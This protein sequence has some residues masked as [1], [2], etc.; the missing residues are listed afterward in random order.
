MAD[1]LKTSGPITV[2]RTTTITDV[3]GQKH[4]G[5]KQK[6]VVDANQKSLVSF[7]VGSTTKLQVAQAADGKTY[8]SFDASLFTT[9]D[10]KIPPAFK[11]GNTCMLE[12]TKTGENSPVS[13]DFSKDE[14][15]M[16]IKSSDGQEYTLFVHAGGAKLE[17]G[18]GD[19]RQVFTYNSVDEKG[20]VV[21]LDASV[22]TECIERLC[23]QN[24]QL[25]S[26]PGPAT[27]S[28]VAKVKSQLPPYYIAL[29]YCKAKGI[30]YDEKRAM[31]TLIAD[32]DPKNQGVSYFV[33]TPPTA[34]NKQN[35]VNPL[36][37][38]KTPD[39]RICFYHDGNWLIADQYFFQTA[40]NGSL[41]L[42]F[43]ITPNNK[44]SYEYTLNT[45]AF[46]KFT[47]ST[48]EN[49]RA[50][51]DAIK[52]LVGFIESG[53]T[54]DENQHIRNINKESNTTYTFDN[55]LV[56]KPAGHDDSQNTPVKLNQKLN[57][58]SATQEEIGGIEPP[59]PPPGPTKTPLKKVTEQKK[60]GPL[61]GHITTIL[62]I[63]L[64]MCS[65]LLGP[66]A[67]AVLASI[68]AL[69]FIG[70]QSYLMLLDH[71]ND[72]LHSIKT[73]YIDPL[74]EQEREYENQQEAFWENDKA[75]DQNLEQ[76]QGLVAEFGAMW[77]ENKPLLYGQE[78]GYNQEN[79]KDFIV[80]PTWDG[81]ISEENIQ[82]RSDLINEYQRLMDKAT[83]SPLEKEDVESFIKTHIYKG[84]DKKIL[85]AIK[86][87]FF[88]D[89]NKPIL[90]KDVIQ[91]FS[92]Y[93]KLQR[94]NLEE[95]K[96]LENRQH[97]IL[98]YGDKRML[99]TAIANPKLTPEQRIKLVERYASDIME[100]FVC[101]SDTDN[102][103]FS[104]FI[105]SFPEQEIGHISQVLLKA[106]E[107]LEVDV[108]LENKGFKKASRSLKVYS[109]F[110]E[111][112]ESLVKLE[113]KFS[114]IWDS[115]STPI[116]ETRMQ[117]NKKILN[118]AAT[119]SNLAQQR[120]LLDEK[121]KSMQTLAS[122]SAL[123]KEDQDH[124][125]NFVES[126]TTFEDDTKKEI[127]NLMMEREELLAQTSFNSDMEIA[128]EKYLTGKEWIGMPHAPSYVFSEIDLKS[129]TSFQVDHFVHGQMAS[130]LAK[131]KGLSLDDCQ[132]MSTDKIIKALNDV[133]LPKEIQL[134]KN[135]HEKNTEIKSKV[136]KRVSEKQASLKKTSS[137][138]AKKVADD[139]IDTIVREYLKTQYG[140]AKNPNFEKERKRLVA[141]IQ[142]IAYRYLATCDLN[143]ELVKG[144]KTAID[145][146]PSLTDRFNALCELCANGTIGSL[147]NQTLL[148]NANSVALETVNTSLTE[149]LTLRYGKKEA[150]AIVKDDKKLQD[151]LQTL[152]GEVKS[153]DNAVA[154]RKKAVISLV[155][156]ISSHKSLAPFVDAFVKH[157]EGAD[158]ENADS[159]L[160]QALSLMD[161]HKVTLMTS[162][163]IYKKDT[164]KNHL[165]SALKHS[166]RKIA[167]KL[168]EAE[169]E[170]DETARNKKINEIIKYSVNHPKLTR[171]QKRQQ[172]KE[173]ALFLAKRD[174]DNQKYAYNEF[175][176]L[177][178]E[179]KD[180]DSAS[181][182]SE[183]KA[184]MA[185]HEDAIKF[186]GIGKA[187][188]SVVITESNI[189]EILGKCSE[190]AE[191]KGAKL[192]KAV[193]KK[194]KKAKKNRKPK[195]KKK[196]R[197]IDKQ[198]ANKAKETLNNQ[199]LWA[200]KREKD[201][202]AAERER[203]SDAER[204][205]G[206]GR[207]SESSDEMGS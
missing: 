125:K 149:M 172:K 79:A 174:R 130:Y 52:E 199:I 138:K 139:K 49:D 142:P 91:A 24:D 112:Y 128:R 136:D 118:N 31:T 205:A 56:I 22:S 186:S 5:L 37:L 36:I 178:Q 116:T 170:K 82:K 182:L 201:A 65:V 35:T 181:K 162:N 84:E 200:R 194:L 145:F 193:K 77:G 54:K 110:T 39:N 9:R 137:S 121:I 6:T 144:K 198:K 155:K 203:E 176:K 159:V 63:G 92:K 73:K 21:P 115:V 197:K 18:E 105:S 107:K 101:E 51:Q 135:L 19:N 104:A 7:S 146:T 25:L 143:N 45:G 171:A 103:D 59:P 140:S 46:D 80:P 86:G 207:A 44:R 141:Q 153:Y 53:V 113:K 177:S 87:K 183:F 202:A 50:K 195:K 123:S 157:L 179:I 99:G 192:Q 60:Y 154:K 191:K 161:S 34:E 43:N 94:D 69:A 66:L 61:P 150:E 111:L 120:D 156:T 166:D 188:N 163:G 3:K 127:A 126:L 29:A 64:M 180:L 119:K 108:S 48:N 58:L 109:G 100:R 57:N 164:I 2:E 151:E 97:N 32:S 147:A 81:F 173:F 189:D 152:P 95:R 55:G 102:L 41:N 10:G 47:A 90:G 75:L 74:T 38:A 106:Q 16:T 167:K 27:S 184:W 76:A 89:K 124:V 133:E 23:D 165:I 70:G 14:T 168:K 122:L 114:N 20:E 68:G 72:P 117:Q 12:V 40:T 187:L 67:G 42:Y 17:M 96:T 93:N 85:D 158:L 1:V 33:Y 175:L 204:E 26:M 15:K 131:T 148:M 30:Q 196:Q 134:L 190:M 98:V 28:G 62:A 8:V 88:D 169:K 185:E 83:S 160:D 206:S 13:I 11:I 132:N 78:F 71:L 4:T 129:S